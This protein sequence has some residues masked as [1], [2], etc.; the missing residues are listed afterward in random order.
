MLKGHNL[1]LLM[2]STLVGAC[3]GIGGFTFYY[4]KG[5][6]YLSSDPKACVNC[7]VMQQEY[8]GWQRSS[9]HA[10]A[11]CVDCHTPA[12]IIGKYLTKAEN[13][14]FHSKA[15][16]LQDYP[17]V[18]QMR[19]RSRRIVNR[20]CLKCHEAMAGEIAAHAGSG[21]EIDQCTRCH[22]GVGH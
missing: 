17:D 5:S 10:V 11:L 14:Y 3:A 18:I 20:A 7:H 2:L 1:G 4:A 21:D 12:N 22:S 8:D 16:T 13:G 15:F 9:H 19:E 6:S